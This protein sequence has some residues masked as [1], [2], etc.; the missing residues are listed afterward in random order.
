MQHHAEDIVER[1]FRQLLVICR[2]RLVLHHA[3]ALLA[4]RIIIDDLPVPSALL[5][6]VERRIRFREKRPILA[7]MLRRKRDADAARELHF[8]R[9][10]AELAAHARTELPAPLDDLFLRN[11]R[12]EHDELITADMTEHVLL[13]ESHFQRKREVEDD[14][15]ANQMAEPVIDLLEMVKVKHEERM[16]PSLHPPEIENLV[17]ELRHICLRIKPRHRI[18]PQALAQRR[19]LA[20]ELADVLQRAINNTTSVHLHLELIGQAEIPD[21]AI[22]IEESE[23]DLPWPRTASS[24]KRMHHE[25]RKMAQEFLALRPLQELGPLQEGSSTLMRH[26]TRQNLQCI[27]IVTKAILPHPPAERKR[28]TDDGTGAI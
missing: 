4:E 2:L 26:G 19:R 11:I 10:F 3:A 20:V 23:H 16:A 9:W 15:I 24:A 28:S 7:A 1:L 22:C 27:I 6:L 12:H 21:I 5:R 25:E 13:A 8:I 14:G 17:D 18:V